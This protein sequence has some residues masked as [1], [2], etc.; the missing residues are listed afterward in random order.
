M[1]GTE[2]VTPDCRRKISGFLGTGLLAAIRWAGLM[3][4]DW[5]PSIE[6]VLP[7]PV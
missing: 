2:E 5:S 6:K 1:F 3:N 4:Y 7:A